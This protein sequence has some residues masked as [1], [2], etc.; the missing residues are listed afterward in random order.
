MKL[1][2]LFHIL[3]GCTDIDTVIR[4]TRTAVEVDW[5]ITPDE[6]QQY[7]VA[8]GIGGD[9][10][11]QSSMPVHATSG[12]PLNT[13]RLFIDGLDPFVKYCFQVQVV[14]VY[15]SDCGEIHCINASTEMCK[16]VFLFSSPF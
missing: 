11:N 7:R 4:L 1:Y 6:G 2:S 10:L 8:Y 14:D 3:A 16:F 9:P 15:P 12:S 5:T 13:Y